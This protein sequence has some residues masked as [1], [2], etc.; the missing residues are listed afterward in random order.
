MKTLLEEYLDNLQKGLLLLDMPTGSGKTYAVIDYI[1]SH[2]QTLKAQQ[3]KILFITPM[4]KNLPFDELK[5]SLGTAL[6]II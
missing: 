6:V 1:A 5:A 4:K 3:R 2:I